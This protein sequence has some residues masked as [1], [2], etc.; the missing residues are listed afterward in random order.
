M[1][2]NIQLQ[3][4]KPCHENW[5]K[6]N[7]TDKGRFCLSCQKEVIDF[8]TM[9]DQQ[10]LHHISKASAG[11]CGK[12]N[13]DQ[14]D[15]DIKENKKQRLIW[16][17]YLVH[18]SIPALLFS[19]KLSAQQPKTIGDTITC[20]DTRQRNTIV[21]KVS[22]GAI[23]SSEKFVIEGK[24][25]DEKGEP[26][27]G[28]SIRMNETK[29]GTSADNAGNFKLGI[30][31]SLKHIKLLVSAIGFEAKEVSLGRN[32][33]K[34]NIVLSLRESVMGEMGIVVY[35][36]KKR[37][38]ILEQ[39]KDTVAN[40]C[41]KE[42]IKVYPNPIHFGSTLNIDFDVKEI[43]E[44]NILVSNISGQPLMQKKIMLTSKNHSEQ[45][46]LTENFSDGL[47]FVTVQNISSKKIFTS[48]ILVD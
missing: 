9:S 36:K 25:V 35:T 39:I 40:I 17:K 47:Y 34:Q 46:S 37:K 48:K 24:V 10:I 45:M 1:Q 7:P 28:A 42:S 15:R 29:L 6:M 14:L 32:N 5:D 43:G 16:Y 27:P 21:G 26:I 2:K 13:N 23:E 18:V 38:P 4:P 12:F 3:V 30:K 19:N 44:Y 33:N 20:V 11:F 31:E 22:L 8:S 41:Y